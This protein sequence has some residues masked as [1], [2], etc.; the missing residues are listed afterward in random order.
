MKPVEYEA[1]VPYIGPNLS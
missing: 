1:R